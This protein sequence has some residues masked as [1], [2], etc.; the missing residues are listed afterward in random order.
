MQAKPELESSFCTCHIS[1]C[2]IV[3]S[4]AN[5]PWLSMQELE[6]MKQKL[7]ELEEE[8]VKLRSAQVS[9]VGGCI[10]KQSTT[11]THHISLLS[12]ASLSSWTRCGHTG[13][14]TLLLPCDGSLHA[15]C[16]CSHP[17]SSAMQGNPLLISTSPTLKH[18]P[19]SHTACVW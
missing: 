2:L 3:V 14:G 9:W 8:A 13:V 7:K 6:A 10:C 11:L 12:R 18:A 17:T 15:P 19:A 16:W 4:V 1:S 5:R